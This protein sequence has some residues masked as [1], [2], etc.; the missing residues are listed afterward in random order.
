M[1]TCASCLV[2]SSFPPGVS[3]LIGG[4]LG[5][6]HEWEHL[7]NLRTHKL[8]RF[9]VGLER[10]PCHCPH[11][12][13]DVCCFDL[14]APEAQEKLFVRMEENNVEAKRLKEKEKLKV[15]KE[16]RLYNQRWRNPRRLPEER[17]NK[18]RGSRRRTLCETY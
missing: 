12:S 1:D 18:T 11:A 7:S 2:G 6:G 17:K 10:C 15:A 9:P 13:C 5:E 14:L 8:T 4:F 16:K 3:T